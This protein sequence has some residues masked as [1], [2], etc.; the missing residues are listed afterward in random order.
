M[1]K[2]LISFLDFEK[3]EVLEIVRRASRR[4]SPTQNMRWR[5]TTWIF[6]FQKPS[7][8]TRLSLELAIRAHGGE[9]VVLSMEEC[10]LE[11]REPAEHV[12]KVL[13]RWAT[14]LVLRGTHAVLEKFAAESQNL[15]VLNALTEKE[16]PL[17]ILADLT[18]VYQHKQKLD[19][20]WCFI[21][22]GNNVCHSL[23]LACAMLD[24]PLTVCTP[25]RYAPEQEIV[26]KARKHNARFAYTFTEDPR[27]AVRGAEV[28]YTDTWVSMGQE[29]ERP[30][31]LR[32]FRPFQITEKLLGG[33]GENA[34]LL[35]CLPAHPGEEIEESL[36]ERESIWRQAENRYYASLALLEILHAA[37]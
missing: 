34:I 31:R 14:G 21:G 36:L 24:I 18:T 6:F 22:D 7:L 32:V 9:T 12:A 33:S 17:Q 10:Q 3:E 35:H 28:I 30:E 15:F 26:E 37:H 8:R 25:K 19:V 2:H 5:G 4:A 23:I 29:N 13:S 1:K 20:P 11:K 16:H 27:K